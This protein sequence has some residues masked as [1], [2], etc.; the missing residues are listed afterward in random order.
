MTRSRWLGS[1]KVGDRVGVWCV[2]S[3]TQVPDRMQGWIGIITQRTDSTFQVDGMDRPVF[4][5][6]GKVT[7]PRA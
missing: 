6:Q 4:E 1:L 3:P 5:T 7:L 2:C